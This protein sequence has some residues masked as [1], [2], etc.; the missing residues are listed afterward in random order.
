MSKTFLQ[1]FE[2]Y[3][4]SDVYAEILK[5]ADNIK[6]QADKVNR[7]LNASVD[8]PMLVDKD[9]LY[10]IE[11]GIAKAYQ[12]N[13]MK[14]MPHY[15][16]ELFSE[17][18]VP[19]LMK[20]TEK[21]GIVARG[22]FSKY[23]YKFDDST[24][25]IEIPFSKDGVSLLHDARTPAVMQAIILSEFGIQ[26]K[27]NIIHTN[28]DDFLAS[29]NS[30]E[31]MLEEYD[32]RM[33]AQIQNYATHATSPA[34]PDTPEML[35][36]KTTLFEENAHADVNEGI[37]VI[38]NAK[39][40][41]S[42]PE[43]VIGDPFVISP[44]SIAE[45]TSPQRN[46]VIVGTAFDYTQEPSRNGDRMNISFSITDQTSSVEVRCFV[47]IAEA[48][49]ISA[50]ISNGAVL[51]MKGYAK[52]ELR[53]DKTEGTD[54]Q[55]FFSNVAKIKRLKRVDN[56]PVKRV[57]LHLHTNMSHMDALIPPDVAVKQAKAWGHPAVAITDHGTVQ[58]Y[59]EAMLASEKIG[60]SSC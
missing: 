57:E 11:A 7:M 8:F 47:P 10:D 43:F 38:G 41:I 25:T 1:I 20:E 60:A 48:G 18:Y 19:Q 54:F 31:Q 59:Q 4:P 49:D 6:I 33:A 40:D 26:I 24:L 28:D 50:N 23:R 55:F 56:A 39:F 58:G 30:L 34:I 32:K 2:K 29:N 46:I 14:I 52:K 53:R 13:M 27:V 15:P 35:P 42:E 37:C 3:K 12:L 21:V 44:I 16:A 36:R 9:E 17:S 45:I 5:K 22:F 51:A